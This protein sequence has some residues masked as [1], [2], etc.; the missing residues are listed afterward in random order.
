M[1]RCFQH[2][3]PSPCCVSCIAPQSV[4]VGK[5]CILVN[6]KLNPTTNHK[7]IVHTSKPQFPRLKTLRCA[8]P[9]MC[10]FWVLTHSSLATLTAQFRKTSQKCSKGN[11]RLTRPIQPPHD[12]VL[13]GF[14]SMWIQRYW[15]RKSRITEEN[16][17]NISASPAVSEINNSITKYNP[18]NNMTHLYRHHNLC[19]FAETIPGSKR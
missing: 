3:V 16:D 2:C 12:F 15:S 7:N 8:A 13:R 17:Q 11:K 18:S 10:L 1:Y 19:H 14:I 5:S 6:W 9:R 4:L